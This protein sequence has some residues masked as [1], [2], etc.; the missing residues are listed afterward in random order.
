MNV[1]AESDGP[2]FYLGSVQQILKESNPLSQSS[3]L[4][5]LFSKPGSF[6]LFLIGFK[7]TRHLERQRKD[8]GALFDKT[9]ESYQSKPTYPPDPLLF[10]LWF[11]LNQR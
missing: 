7:R 9:L 4:L 11:G 6:G 5:L 10:V 2:A 1:Q 3:Q 8:M